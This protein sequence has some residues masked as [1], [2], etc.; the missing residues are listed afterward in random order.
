MHYWLGMFYYCY[1]LDHLICWTR[2][3]F[4]VNV[5]PHVSHS[6]GFFP[7]CTL[8]EKCI[9]VGNIL[10]IRTC[11]LPHMLDKIRFASKC[12]PTGFTF[13]WL[14]SRVHPKKEIY[15]CWEI[16]TIMTCWLPHMHDKIRF[17]SRCFP[18][19]FT[20]EKFFSGVHTKKKKKLFH[21]YWRK[22]QNW[23]PHVV[24][25]ISFFSKCFSTVFTLEISFSCMHT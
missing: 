3:P 21:E 4:L 13:E 1:M 25:K 2:F 18:T 12:F 7:V 5:C 17:A 8:K 11:W 22:V 14:F 24:N 16:L 9:T 23:S 20:F 10:T 19:G 15:Y 6:K